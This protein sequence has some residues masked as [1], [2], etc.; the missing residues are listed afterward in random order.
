MSTDPVPSP[1]LPQAGME[2]EAHWLS[3]FFMAMRKKS[4]ALQCATHGDPKITEVKTQ[5]AKLD[6]NHPPSVMAT[7]LTE[8]MGRGLGLRERDW[9]FGRQASTTM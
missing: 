6:N 5:K 1:P 4:S 2:A 7:K 8:H 3:Q 9:L